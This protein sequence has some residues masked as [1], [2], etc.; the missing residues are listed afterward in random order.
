MVPYIAWENHVYKPRKFAFLIQL[1]NRNT[2]YRLSQD[3]SL[4]YR[5][6]LRRQI[7]GGDTSL[8]YNKG[9]PDR[10]APYDTDQEGGHKAIHPQVAVRILAHLKPAAGI[11]DYIF[12]VCHP[13]VCLFDD[14]CGIG[15]VI[16]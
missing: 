8:R 2:R 5:K 3:Q 1:P 7:A 6:T 14:G 11:N 9:R 12:S 10:N 15:R 4:F 16:I 13:L